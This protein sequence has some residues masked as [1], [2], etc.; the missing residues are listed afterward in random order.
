MLSNYVS[1]TACMKRLYNTRAIIWFAKSTERRKI[2][3]IW[4][5]KSY[6]QGRKKIWF[7]GGWLQQE[8]PQW[9]FTMVV[10]YSAEKGVN[11]ILLVHRNIKILHTCFKKENIIVLVQIKERDSQISAYSAYLFLSGCTT[12]RMIRES[13]IAKRRTYLR[14]HISMQ[15]TCTNKSL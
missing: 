15:A 5:W 8:L 14:I 10:T 9:W 12:F 13:Q 6:L 2:N 4:G 1:I 7:E 3:L 11:C